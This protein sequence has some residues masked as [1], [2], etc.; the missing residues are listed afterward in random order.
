MSVELRRRE[1]TALMLGAA[2]SAGLG[3]AA[4]A[5]SDPLPSWN[6]GSAK[7]A[8]LNFVRETTDSSRLS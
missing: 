7:E 6:D 1:F 5:Q 3:G 8:I 2:A 4:Q